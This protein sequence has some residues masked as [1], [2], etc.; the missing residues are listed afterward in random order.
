[1]PL[2]SKVRVEV[3]RAGCTIAI[4]YDTNAEIPLHDI[5]ADLERATIAEVLK[6]SDGI[7]A[8]AAERLML[9]RTTLVEKARKYGFP[10]KNND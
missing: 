3:K 7:K 1:M 8:R 2:N 4:D 6:A 10:M 9:N 5:L